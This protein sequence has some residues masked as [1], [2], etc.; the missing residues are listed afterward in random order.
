MKNKRWRKLISI[1][2]A[3][4]LMAT[5]VPFA[6][7]AEE[8][9]EPE[10][11]DIQTLSNEVYTK[12]LLHGN[13]RFTDTVKM[14]N[15]TVLP[16]Y[17]KNLLYSSPNLSTSNTE[18]PITI[19]ISIS[20]PKVVVGLYDGYNLPT[21]PVTANL[22]LTSEHRLT[23]LILSDESLLYETSS[24]TDYQ[25][26]TNIWRGVNANLTW[27]TPEDQES[28]FHFMSKK[29]DLGIDLFWTRGNYNGYQVS[30][31]N[32]LTPK[33]EYLKSLFRETNNGYI[34]S[35]FNDTSFQLVLT[36]AYDNHE[37]WISPSRCPLGQGASQY[38]I[39]S[40]SINS[41]I[42]KARAEFPQIRK[43][44][45]QYDQE[46]LIN[47]YN[48][49]K[50][51]LELNINN[52]ID[53][54]DDDNARTLV[55]ALGAKIQSVSAEY[56]QARNEL[57]QMY[58]D[59]ETVEQNVKD[60][61][62]NAS[63]SK[64][65]GNIYLGSTAVSDITFQGQNMN[66]GK[67]L[68]YCSK[69]S[70]IASHLVVNNVDSWIE[71][72]ATVVMIYD[73]YNETSFP[74]KLGYG[75]SSGATDWSGS[76][77]NSL[78]LGN[79]VTQVWG[80]SST[81]YY[82]GN[83]YWVCSNHQSAISPGSWFKNANDIN[84]AVVNGNTSS[85]GV[86]LSNRYGGCFN[87]IVLDNSK[88]SN[89]LKIEPLERT[90]PISVYL[91]YANETYDNYPH[92]ASN[93]ARQ[94]VINIR[95]LNEKIQA[96]KKDYANLTANNDLDK[97]ETASK[98]RYL[99]AI[100]NLISFSI[101]EHFSDCS[102]E[103]AY[104]IVSN[105]Q[106]EID[107]FCAEYDA[108]LK[109][110]VKS[111][112]ITFTN[113]DGE[114]VSEQYVAE[115]EKAVVPENTAPRKVSASSKN[116]FSFTWPTVNVATSDLNYKERRSAVPC[117]LDEGTVTKAATCTQSGE[118]TYH[119]SVC[120]GDMYEIINKLDHDFSV[121]TA[122][123][124]TGTTFSNTLKHSLSC[125]VGGEEL[126]SETCSFEK[127]NEGDATIIYECSVCKGLAVYTKAKFDITFVDKNGD[128][129]SSKTYYE[130]QTIDIPDL[131]NANVDADGHH[132]Y[133]WN[134]EPS[135]IPSADI[136]YTVI[137]SVKAHTYGSYTYNDDATRDDIYGT[138]TAVCSVA[139]CTFSDTRPCKDEHLP[140]AFDITG[141]ITLADDTKGTASNIP[142][143]NITVSVNNTEIKAITD[144]DGKYTLKGLA[145]GEY[146][147]TISGDST[148]DRQATLIVNLDDADID[149]I[150]VDDIGIIAFDYNK[151]G[152]I[153]TVDATLHTK[154]E[155]YRD[156]T[157]QFKAIFN[158]KIVY[159]T[160]I[161]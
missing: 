69:K 127:I 47:Y 12:L 63:I 50:A 141:K 101:N 78:Y 91:R 6:A 66:F 20:C 97:Y 86:V 70:L 102:D 14:G 76:N 38:I 26:C 72:P 122:L 29:E 39:D 61:I 30:C 87:K 71:T 148:I 5:S 37:R 128:T 24:P 65:S 15:K 113:Y 93:N 155:L 90:Q 77:L 25:G 160:V 110:L 11:I 51:V 124:K 138:E 56:T 80:S 95:S 111:F 131:P 159:N 2:M 147:I 105:C 144:K 73:G 82:A 23:G 62:A 10:T 112:K 27:V 74:I 19:D 54:I 34:T 42:T 143:V 36:T 154:N 161:V 81:M 152:K 28:I 107:E 49:L 115:G 21:F 83:S 145:E 64:P 153:N 59:P 133:S 1:V 149:Q 58:K 52:E 118:M 130:G 53:G 16:Y 121:Y 33:G 106:N 120:N 84:C 31:S 46:K 108:A 158:K 3:V 88:Y 67:N 129:I 98:N 35:T 157:K 17:Y 85:A 43:F 99:R 137:D 40:S 103:N 150:T 135:T 151:D 89:S 136:T 18:Q 92:R 48:A 75:K 94:Y 22:Y 68:A 79:E 126:Y 140:T 7:I 116:H 13:T 45:D 96:A 60:N 55:K 109:G 41:I 146:T 156:N 44:G 100:D 8:T 139:G 123:Y 4:L 57:G 125:S 117:T 142:A 104:E 119:C 134:T 114:I 132:S 32:T 9:T